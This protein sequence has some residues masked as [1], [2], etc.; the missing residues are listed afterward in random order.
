VDPDNLRPGLVAV[1]RDTAGPTPTEVYQRDPTIAVNWKA[2]ESAHPRLAADGGSARWEGYVNVLR[3]G[4]YRFSVWLRGKFRLRVTGREVLAA[5][6]TGA[7]AALREGP[8][9]QL[10]AGVH[11][12][13]ADFT[14]LPGAARVELLWQAPHFATEPLPY[15]HLGHLPAAVPQRLAVDQVVERGRFLAE[16][17]SCTRCHQPADGDRLAR[18][19]Q[20][21]QGPDLSKVGERAYPGWIFH[22]LEAPH[23]LRPGTAMPQMFADDEAGRVER[24]L[25]ARYL[26]SLGGP[27]KTSGKR[28]SRLPDVINRRQR[29]FASLGCVTCHGD[30]KTGS[31]P[32]PARSLYALA[33]GAGGP[34]VV[35]LTGL[36]SKTNPERLAAYLQNPLAVD[37]SGRMPN[38]LLSGKE[39]EE[40][41]WFLCNSKVPGVGR[42]LPEPPKPE[43]IRETFRRV[44]ARPEEL[45]AFARFPAEQQP[46]ELGKRLVIDKGCNQCHTI[47]PQGQPFAAVL[48]S[49]S[50]DDVKKPAAQAKG[51]LADDRAK[52][53]KAPWFN[54]GNQDRTA[55]RAFLQEGTRG[56]GTG[57]PAYAARVTL[58]R[59]NC[60]AC[61]NR[62]G[63]GGLTSQ[64]IEDVRKFD[65]AENAEA[66]SPPPLTG[67]AHKLRTPWLKQVLTGAGRARPWMS[68]RMPQFGEANVG[69]LPTAL[70]ALEGVEPEDQVYRVPLSAAGIEAGR[71][72]VGRQAFG[73]ISC[74]D[75]AGVVNAGTRGPDLAL[76]N[77]RV[78]YP[79]YR[80]WLEQ[81]QRMQAGTRM[82]T[83]FP[84]GH[85][86]LATVLDGKAEA[87]ADAIWAYL[88]LGPALPLPEGLDPPKGLVVQVKDRPVVLR[89]FMPDAGARALAVGFP[90]GVSVAFDAATCRLAYAWSGNFLDATPVWANRGGSP[91]HILGAR[92]WNAPRGCPLVVTPSEAPPD[93]DA[94]VNDP[95][96][97]VSPPEGVL[98]KG[99]RQLAFEGYTVD[100]DGRPTFRY[101]LNAAETSPVEVQERPEPLQSPVAFGV[102]R[103][104]SFTLPAQQKAWLLA[105]EAN[106]EPRLLDPTGAEVKLDWK[107][108]AA[109][110]PTAG[111]VLKLPQ[112]GDKVVLLKAAAAPEGS[113]WL[114][115]R[116]GGGWQALL[117]IPAPAAPAR[118]HIDLNLWAPYRDEPGLVKELVRGK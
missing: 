76:M 94:H 92:F 16:E 15:D 116:Q 34:S 93:F 111:G 75:I 28:P 22:W 69:H 37:P 5:E 61:H 35:R 79:W 118:V 44:D 89:T 58:Q 39:A 60:L 72:M 101:R 85:S 46:V 48:A 102:K 40:L 112:G 20:P 6:V 57:A 25:V 14:R 87:Q 13:V 68:L 27:V 91:A 117:R 82:P 56:A 62:D 105:A 33:S 106:G 90:R 86:T 32:A 97:G 103:R 7:A 4:P 84:D 80:R 77:Q 55:L 100:H 17:H 99:P 52:R 59:F 113:R 29:L 63:E 49:A 110:L 3:P 26:A 31:Q 107:A 98:Y 24:Y 51:C 53:G 30:E 19:L 104:F 38:L 83:I 108:G 81:A 74:H 21:R 8:E 64:F 50:F 36:G 23:R 47:A 65:K 1:Y 12:L 67:V 45:A 96:Y 95:A 2:G 66:V 11:P 41:A 43:Q 71:A 9:V 18:G 115:V 54:L 114:L 10:E 42:E 88:S 73:C 109:E 70:A 78:R